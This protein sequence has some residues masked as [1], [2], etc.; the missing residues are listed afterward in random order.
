MLNTDNGKSESNCK[1]VCRLVV[2]VYRQSRERILNMAS[3]REGE[4]EN[5]LSGNEVSAYINLAA[6]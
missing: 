6:H 5:L 3:S 4:L 1:K 2:V